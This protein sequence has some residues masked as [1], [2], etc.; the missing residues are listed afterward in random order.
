MSIRLKLFTISFLSL[1]TFWPCFLSVS[2]G[3]IPKPLKS[4]HDDSTLPPACSSDEQSK[5]KSSIQKLAG[6]RNP[7]QAWNLVEA[8]LCGE[9]KKAED[10]VQ[11]Y[12]AKG[13]THTSTGTGDERTAVRK[14]GKH[15]SLLLQKQAWGA[16]AS[17]GVQK[18][19]VSYWRDEA[20]VAGFEILFNNQKWRLISL[21]EAC[22]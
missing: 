21:G 12:R 10:Y 1:G 17:G 13:L 4:L 6:P 9:G 15:E 20:C 11:Q 3:E 7:Q 5:L 16:Q 19:H 14:V 18:I 8:L 2:A 22:D